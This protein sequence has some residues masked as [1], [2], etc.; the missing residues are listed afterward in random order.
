LYLSF[1]KD[2]F[3]KIEIFDL[4]GKLVDLKLPYQSEVIF[5]GLNPGLYILSVSQ[6][7]GSFTQKIWVD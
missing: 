2:G 4:T 5:S 6:P 3:R 1:D 7:H